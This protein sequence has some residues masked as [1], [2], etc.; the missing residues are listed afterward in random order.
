MT[1]P[2][3]LDRAMPQWRWREVHRIA[4]DTDRDDVIDTV[5]A[6]ACVDMPVFRSITRVVSLGRLA[7]RRDE[8]V[9]NLL[10][11]GPYRELHQSAEELVVAGLLNAP[12]PNDV[13]PFDTV[14]T[15]R[16]SSPP[17]N[18][19]VATNFRYRDG[20]LSTE[21]RCQATNAASARAFGRCWLVIR[22]GSGLIRR[23]WLHAIR[24]RIIRSDTPL[25]GS[26]RTRS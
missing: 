3:E 8:R 21:T 2:T 7:R 14:D 23:I 26:D 16:A 1:T 4:I 18:V 6:L 19:K 12:A 15:F 17:R 9:L 10:L 24:R 13:F 5:R 20:L 11:D 25:A 22:A